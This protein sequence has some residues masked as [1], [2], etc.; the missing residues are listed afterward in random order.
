MSFQTYMTFFCITQNMIF[1]RIFGS[2]VPLTFFFISVMDV[3]GNR[4]HL[5]TSILQNI[6]LYVLPKK[7][8]HFW[9][10]MRVNKW[11]NIQFRWTLPFNT[12][13]CYMGSVDSSVARRCSQC[14]RLTGPQICHY[15]SDLLS[16]VNSSTSKMSVAPPSGKTEICKVRQFLL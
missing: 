15:K 7:V 13:N 5:A 11:Q 8:K 1:W 3:N 10:D 16:M 12:W 2:S 6:F 4:N 9:N 14:L